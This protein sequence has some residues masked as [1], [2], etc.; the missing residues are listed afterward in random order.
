MEHQTS[1]CE[2]EDFYD[3]RWE[4]ATFINN[5]KLERCRAILGM[6]LKIHIQK[7]RI[8][9]LG[10]GTG[11]LTSI[12][13][14]YGPTKGVELS[15]AAVEAAKKRYTHVCFDAANILE[16]SDKSGDYDI[17]VSH[18]VLEHIEDQPGYLK[19]AHE[20]LKPG[21][22]LVLTTPNKKVFERYLKRKSDW[23]LQP[24]ENWLTR[25]ELV[26][27]LSASGFSVLETTT[28]LA[29]PDSGF[30]FRLLMSK[31]PRGIFKMLGLADEYRSVL[32]KMGCGLHIVILAQKKP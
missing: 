1:I 21:G 31:I 6:L 29:T 8:I 2:Q 23:K 18:E 5:C 14:E 22:Y 27:I 28:A 12:L 11:W 15:P 10:A 4:S 17:A 30:I 9:E 20:L 3:E 32:L 13:G 24:I 16:F 26:Q 25:S 19:K 7:P